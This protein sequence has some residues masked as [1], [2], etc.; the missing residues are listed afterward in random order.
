MYNLPNIA[1]RNSKLIEGT[2]GSF[3]IEFAISQDI[4]NLHDTGFIRGASVSIGKDA[5]KKDTRICHQSQLENLRSIIAVL[6]HAI[7]FSQWED[8]IRRRI[9]LALTF[10]NGACYSPVSSYS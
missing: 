10:G 6:D 8:G 9:C 3:A 2:L 1:Q 5:K 4:A 7:V